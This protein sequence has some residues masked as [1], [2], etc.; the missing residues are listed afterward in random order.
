M[1]VF[2]VQVNYIRGFG[3]KWSNVWHCASDGIAAASADWEE[4]GIPDL[5]PMLDSSCQIASY[6]INDPASTEFITKP[7]NLAGTSTASGDLLPLFNSCK[8]ILPTAGFGR[9]DLKYFKGFVTESI[10]TSGNLLAGT[11]TAVE[12]LVETLIADMDTAGSPLC[13]QFGEVYSTVSVQQAVQ[14]RQM[15][16]KRRKAVATP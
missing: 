6:L 13:S 5:R 4:V 16:R 9:P 1:P 2:R 14:M 12:T 15:H 3:E 8:V 10:Q 7:V 11:L